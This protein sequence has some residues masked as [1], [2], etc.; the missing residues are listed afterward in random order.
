VTSRGR[1]ITLGTFLAVALL[2]AVVLAFF[3][4][5]HASEEPD[6]LERVATDEG[7]AQR[8]V[9]HALERSPTAGY[10]VD[11]VDSDRWST[12]AA[13]LIGVAVSFA[14]ATGVL[15]VVRRARP[16]TASDAAAT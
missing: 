13:G 14:F 12:A 2:V 5:P 11:G 1:G 15:L 16:A 3:L 7:F 4:S 6:G 10:A 8:E 9:A